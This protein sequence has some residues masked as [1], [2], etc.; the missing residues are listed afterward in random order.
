MIKRDYFSFFVVLL[1]ASLTLTAC[2]SNEAEDTDVEVEVTTTTT[3]TVVAPSDPVVSQIQTAVTGG[4]GG[5]V[6]DNVVID[7]SAGSVVQTTTA[8]TSSS[9]QQSS[10][11]V[12][13]AP[14]VN[15]ATGQPTGQVAVAVASTTAGQTQTQTLVAGLS[16]SNPAALSL[17]VVDQT[18]AGSAYP[19]NSTL[20]LQAASTQSPDVGRQA[21]VSRFN[22]IRSANP[23]ITDFPLASGQTGRQAIQSALA[24]GKRS[25][26]V[27]GA[28]TATLSGV[29]SSYTTGRSAARASCTANSSLVTVQFNW[30]V[31]PF[32][33]SETIPC[34]TPGALRF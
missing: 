4:F 15:E 24:S 27:A 28:I 32:A 16:S 1:V 18:G 22:Q 14:L 21:W 8:S 25:A 31:G 19:L 34:A 10:T 12:T 29:F 17:A 23:N 26:A 6:P 3:E 9:G 7:T 20:D 33:S 5:V 2:D 13:V 11:A 30:A